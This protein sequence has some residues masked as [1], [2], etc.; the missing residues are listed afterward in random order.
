MEETMRSA[1]WA[2]LVVF[3]LVAGC[4]GTN[5][6]VLVAKDASTGGAG[7]SSTGGSGGAVMDGG[8]DGDSGS[9]GSQL[10]DAAADS[11]F[12]ADGPSVF[13]FLHGIPNARA[14]RVCFEA[15]TET[16]YAPTSHPPLPEDALGLP[17]GRALSQTTL[18]GV[19]LE[20]QAVRPA[21]YGGALELIDGKQCDQ[22]VEPPQGVQRAT[23]P[24]IPAGTLA[25]GRSVLIVAVGCLG[26]LPYE[27][28]VVEF[29]CGSGF[30]PDEGNAGL[31]VASMERTP[32][33][34]GMGTQVFAAS[35][36][37]GLLSVDHVAAS[38]AETRTIVRDLAAGKIAPRPPSKEL[39][40]QSLGTSPGDN[41]LRVYVDNSPDPSVVT[42]L[43]DALGRG[44][45][46]VDGL[47][48]GS[49][50][51]IVLVGPRPG[52]EGD[53]FKPHDVVMIP[54]AP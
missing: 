4:Q 22:I 41:L 13:T 15:Q 28:E 50:Y 45:L 26:G 21:V 10:T 7:G 40:L 43:S 29:V 12:V 42:L 48:D 23:L 25:R 53:W 37:S 51:T 5:N 1:A 30:V 6:D 54:S 2:S 46:S 44:G 17:F 18:P 24:A 35:L 19:D 27:Q 32:L 11:S 36:G 34:Q 38:T 3:I 47:Q 16:G 33:K 49:N 20:A 39:S 14:L 52:L 9:G 31:L 8:E